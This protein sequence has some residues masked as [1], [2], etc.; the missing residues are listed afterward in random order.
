MFLFARREI[1]AAGSGRSEVPLTSSPEY[2]GR[3]ACWAVNIE[4]SVI[5]IVSNAA[6]KPIYDFST[7]KQRRLFTFL[8][9]KKDKEER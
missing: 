2:W 5:V 8:P 3:R 4:F 7:Q 9:K 6:R 1:P